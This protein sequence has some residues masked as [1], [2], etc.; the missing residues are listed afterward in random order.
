MPRIKRR[1]HL[2]NIFGDLIDMKKFEDKQVEQSNG[3]IEYSG[4]NHVQGYQ[5]VGRIRGDKSGFITAHRL[6]M[7]LKLGRDLGPK[8]QVIHTCSNVKCVNPDHLFLGDTRARVKNMTDNGRAPSPTRGHYGK[9]NT[10][11]NRK[12]KYSIEDMVFIRTHTPAEIREK[13]GIG[14]KLSNRLKSGYTT[15]Y[16]W[17]DDYVKK[18]V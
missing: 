18:E 6:A 15:G 5:F 8:E 7:K 16:S 4:I 2:T 9:R 13:F 1:D 17:L 10:P 12:Y 11:Q 3:C 14:V